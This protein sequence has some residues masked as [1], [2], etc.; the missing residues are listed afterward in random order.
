MN[1][2]VFNKW[3]AI[4]VNSFPSERVTPDTQDIYF[5]M[6][7]PI[8]EKFFIE[9]IKRILSEKTFFPSISE[10]GDASIGTHYLYNPRVGSVPLNWRESLKFAR[11]RRRLDFFIRDDP[12]SEA[13]KFRELEQ[14]I[15]LEAPEDQPKQ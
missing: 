14:A 4:L 6:L 9:G 11:E 15:L 2:E 7:G 3:F 1:R 13:P 5:E 12:R 8:P 10:I